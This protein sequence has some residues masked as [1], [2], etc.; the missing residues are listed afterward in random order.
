MWVYYVCIHVCVCIYVFVCVYICIYPPLKLRGLIE[1]K[2]EG[3]A[4]RP[5]HTFLSLRPLEVAPSEERPGIT[6]RHFY[7]TNP[8]P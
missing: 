3:S 8:L 5:C 1:G 7:F 2:I 6:G 4:D